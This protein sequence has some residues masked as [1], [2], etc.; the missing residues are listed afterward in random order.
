MISQPDAHNRKRI[1]D[2]RIRTVK[3]LPHDVYRMLH[4]DCR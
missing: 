4:R 1:E 3:H 2:L